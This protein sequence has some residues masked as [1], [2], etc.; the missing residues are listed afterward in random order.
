MEKPCIYMLGGRNVST[1]KAKPKIMNIRFSRPGN[2]ELVNFANNQSF[3][4]EKFSQLDSNKEN[5]CDA[6]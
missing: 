6:T 2:S 3:E 4:L 5:Q 1:A